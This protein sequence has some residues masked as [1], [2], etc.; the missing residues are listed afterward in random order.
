MSQTHVKPD[1]GSPPSTPR[2]VKVLVIIAIVLI[3]LFVI[4]HLTG[5]SLGGP[6]GHTMPFSVIELGVQQP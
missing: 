1:R 5:N 4:L 6:G 3:L 2:W